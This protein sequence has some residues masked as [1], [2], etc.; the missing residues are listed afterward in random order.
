MKTIWIAWEQHRRTRE[1]A[2]SMKDVQLF[3]LDMNAGRWIRYPILLLKSLEVLWAQKPD[4]VIIQNPSMVLALFMVTVGRLFVKNIVVDAHNEGIRPYYATHH[5]LLPLY[6][7]VQKRSKL[8]IVTNASLAREVCKNGGR[9]F[10]LEDKIPQIKAAAQVALKGDYNIVFVCT[11]EKDEPFSE[12]IDSGAYLD[13]G[14]CIYITG[15][16]SKLSKEI[17]T[18]APANIIF[19]GYLSEQDYKN[20]LHSC[21]VVMDLTLMDDCLVCGAYEAVALNKPMILT[22]TKALKNYFTRGAVYTG[23]R[24]HEIAASVETAIKRL[25]AL[26]KEIVTLKTELQQAWEKKFA[27]LSRLI[28]S[29]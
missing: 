28:E 2:A 4:T 21:D 7:F 13:P 26:K 10:I 22:H 23:N 12:V 14:T 9:P 29:F 25:P 17:I 6:A 11:F 16:Y 3:A 5:W 19:T 24:S 1:I 27:H 18:S 20:L 8:T 15:Q